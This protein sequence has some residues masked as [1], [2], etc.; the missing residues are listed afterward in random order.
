VLQNKTYWNQSCASV[1]PNR[2]CTSTVCAA[3][4]LMVQMI[5]EANS[6]RPCKKVIKNSNERTKRKF[7]EYAS[8][9][10]I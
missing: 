3:R 1:Y 4:E 8:Q 5:S 10:R 7:V 9:N 6:N 2:K